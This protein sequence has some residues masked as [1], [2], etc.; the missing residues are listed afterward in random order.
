MAAPSR[1]R[2]IDERAQPVSRVLRFSP[3]AEAVALSVAQAAFPKAVPVATHREVKRN[4]QRAQCA[5]TRRL[6][7]AR[8]WDGACSAR[9]A[10]RVPAPASC[11][12]RLR[13][14][15]KGDSEVA[16]A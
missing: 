8:P 1:P 14:S 10:T 13:P 15:G 6:G 11:A 7:S 9:Q 4:G 5:A 16:V 3:P 12:V 2:D